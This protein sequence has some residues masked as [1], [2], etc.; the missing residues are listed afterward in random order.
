MGMLVGLKLS[1]SNPWAIL[2]DFTAF[3]FSGPAGPI[4]L[5]LVAD[6]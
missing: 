1:D 5:I 6:G 3:I 4:A 2:G